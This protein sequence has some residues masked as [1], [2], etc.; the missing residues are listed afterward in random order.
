MKEEQ[1]KNLMQKSTVATSDDFTDALMQQ[2]ETLEETQPIKLISFRKIVAFSIASL[3]ILS[4]IAYQYVTPFLS[5]LSGSVQINKTPIFAAFLL[6]CLL[7][8]NYVL[9]LQRSYRELL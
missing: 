4:L 3:V 1:L 6:L 9:R 2:L 8:L 7:G 5:E